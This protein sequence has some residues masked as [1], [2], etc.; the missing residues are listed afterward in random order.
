MPPPR[1][2]TRRVVRMPVRVARARKRRKNLK[3]R[4][5]KKKTWASHYSNKR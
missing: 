3:K 4:S 5:K 2:M 1:V